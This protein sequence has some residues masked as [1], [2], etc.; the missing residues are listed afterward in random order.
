MHVLV[1]LF[2]LKIQIW[3]LFFFSYFFSSQCSYH[4]EHNKH[5]ELNGIWLVLLKALKDYI[6]LCRLNLSRGAQMFELSHQMEIPQ[7]T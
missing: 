4:V 6:L 7:R 5:V 1:I 2:V 3:T